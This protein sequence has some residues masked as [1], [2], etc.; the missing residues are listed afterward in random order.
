MLLKTKTPMNP[1]C[2]T[3]SSNKVFCYC[4]DGETPSGPRCIL[5]EVDHYVL[6]LGTVVTQSISNITMY[7]ITRYVAMNDIFFQWNYNLL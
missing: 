7:N 2:F 4:F 1:R 6:F 3:T 5:Y